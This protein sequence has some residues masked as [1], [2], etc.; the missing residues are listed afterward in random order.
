MFKALKKRLIATLIRMDYED[1][2]H[3]LICTQEGY[4]RE[5]RRRI[6]EQIGKLRER[7]AQYEIAPPRITDYIGWDELRSLLKG[8]CKEPTIY[9]SDTS[10]AL[11]SKSEM[12]RFLKEDLVDLAKYTPEYYDCDDFSFRLHGA[13]SLPV[14][15]GIA[16]GIAWSATHAY[17]IFVDDER[18]VW[19]IEPQTDQL[20]K[21]SNVSPYDTRLI[22]M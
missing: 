21:P 3:R 7:L 14:W 9:L 6:E 12:L 2:E 18:K 15:G 17:N 10:Y 13:L 11:I 1:W 4:W 8:A 5:F 19:I 20:M 16:F 22:I